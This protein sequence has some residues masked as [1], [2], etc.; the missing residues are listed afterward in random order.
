M[1]LNS[2]SSSDVGFNNVNIF[3]ATSLSLFHH[4]SHVLWRGGMIKTPSPFSS[5]WDVV[6]VVTVVVDAADDVFL[7]P[8]VHHDSHVRLV[9]SISLWVSVIV[10]LIPLT[11]LTILTILVIVILQL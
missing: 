1:L 7:E 9:G 2:L 10:A 4:S 6:D 3:L 8:F 11:I 5:C